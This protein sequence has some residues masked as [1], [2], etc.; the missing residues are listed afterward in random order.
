[1]IKVLFALLIALTFMIPVGGNQQAR[2]LTN[3]KPILTRYGM[4]GVFQM[5]L[6]K[7]LRH[8]SK[9]D[10]LLIKPLTKLMLL[11]VMLLVLPLVAVLLLQKP[12][13]ADAPFGPQNVITT[14]AA[15]A[16]YSVYVADVDGDGDMD[17]LSASRDD[18]K[19]VWYEN[20]LRGG[21]FWTPHT[22]TTDA[23]SPY[24]VYAA[25]VD[26]DGDMDALSASRDDDKVAWYENTSGD[27]SSWTPHTITT[28]A[29][30]ATSVYAGDLDGD[31]DMDVLSASFFDDKIAWYENTSGDGSSWMLHTITT[32]ADSARSVYAAD[33]DGDGDMDALSTSTSEDKVAWY[34]NT[35]GDGSSWTPHTITTDADS[36]Y[37][38][39]AADV[40]GDGDIDALSA[41]TN[42]DKIAWYENTSGDGSSWTP[43]TITTDADD[44]RSVYA[45]DMD[46]DDDIDVLSASKG[47]NKIAWYENTSGDGSSW[48]PH[49]ITTDANSA[50]SVYAADMDGDGD[51]DALSASANDDKIAWYENT[52][53][54]DLSVDNSSW[55][56]HTITT[57]AN[58]A[59]SV[60]AADM[61]GD[62]DID[63][64]SASADDDKVVW[65]ENI[66][67]NGSFWRPHT[68]TTNADS[69]QSVHAAD[70]D[71]DG[72]MDALSASTNDDKITWYENTS[73]DGSPGHLTT[74]PL[75]LSALTRCMLR[76]W[77]GTV[78]LTPSPHQCTTIR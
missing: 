78:I 47:D 65:Y 55:T 16:A 38:V 20:T 58:S 19:V 64:L 57:N 23:N 62:G 45:A 15:V 60:H 5:I 43:H 25:D 39:H 52:S 35:S 10:H 48:T 51:I 14:A 9:R 26:G 77:T 11:A 27:G 7:S 59:Q 72:D 56:P 61:D 69:A 22:I 3:I 37:S 21:S 54:D 53:G 71:G 33:V 8:L 75:T 67:G 42:D 29:D 6:I 68:I 74:S 2:K 44:T 34:E 49:T 28:D 73:G 31:G 4:V 24:S 17:A 76:T 50:R 13:F 41:S 63:A 12:V 32:D 66:F 40:D 46:G 30:G 18:N 36:P 1:M 70:V